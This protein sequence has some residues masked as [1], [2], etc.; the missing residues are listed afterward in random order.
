MY[1]V[2]IRHPRRSEGER[3]LFIGQL[4]TGIFGAL[5]ALVVVFRLSPDA[6]IDR[7]ISGFEWWVVTAGFIGGWSATGLAR[8]RLGRRGLGNMLLG[9]GAVTFFAPIIAGTLGLPLYGTMF[10]PFTLALIFVASPIT[11][12]LWAA[13][14]VGVHILFRT[15]HAER[16]SIFGAQMPDPIWRVLW[17]GARK[18]VER[19]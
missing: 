16:D 17:R 3:R 8:E 11:A 19:D 4:M 14:L 9:M 18:L 2:L 7:P 12:L 10:G 6:L 15:W 1:S 13:N 5:L